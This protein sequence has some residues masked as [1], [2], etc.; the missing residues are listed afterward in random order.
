MKFIHKPNNQLIEV[1][2]QISDKKSY[3]SVT[4]LTGK[5]SEQDILDWRK[6]VGDE[7]ADKIMQ[8][9]ADRGTTIHKFCEHYLGNE[10]ILIP[11]NKIG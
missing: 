2:K 6:R 11:E 4:K 8:E 1:S 5:E 3:M 9:S 10:E 7:V